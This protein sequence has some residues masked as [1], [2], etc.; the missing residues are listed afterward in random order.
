VSE[1]VD[2]PVCRSG[3][4]GEAEETQRRARRGE[5]VD[6]LRVGEGVRGWRSRR[7]IARKAELPTEEISARV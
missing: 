4:D 5:R 3:G 2:Y 1:S 6:G 7:E